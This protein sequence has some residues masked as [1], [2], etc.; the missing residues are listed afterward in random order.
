[1]FAA[2]WP[3]A[4]RSVVLAA[5]TAAFVLC[6]SVVV[7][8]RSSAHEATAAVTTKQARSEA[9]EAQGERDEHFQKMSKRLKLTDDQAAKVKSIM[10]AQW[11]QSSELRAKYKGQPV[12]PEN[13]AAMK[14]ARK[15]LHASTDAKIAEVLTATQMTEFKKMRAEHMKHRESE[16][17]EKDEAKEGKE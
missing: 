15:D 8:A 10:E 17:N 11:A 4:V 14:N 3:N 5:T 7:V 16:K 6:M 9:A 2:R 1:M 12:T 13:K